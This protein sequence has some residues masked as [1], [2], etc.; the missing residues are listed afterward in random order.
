MNV[1]FFTVFRADPQH[2]LHAA[3]LVREVRQVMPSARIVQLTDQRTDRLPG[4]DDVRRCEHGPMLQRRMEHYAACDG[5]W[6][7]VDTDV[8]VRKDVTDVFEH[9]GFDVALTDRDWPHD[10]QTADMLRTMPFNTGVVFSRTPEFWRDVLRVWLGYEESARDWM[11]EQRAVYAVVRSGRYRVK[12]LP[13]AI[14]N[15]PPATEADEH[16]DAALVH[17]KGPRKAWMTKRAYRALATP[18][19]VA[20]C[21]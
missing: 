17:Y 8:S 9:G 15:N 13:G 4:V 6:L 2:L 10:P 18:M 21:V 11:S 19:E 3:L 20:V 16:P 1:G 14:Y 5:E 7:L 12:I